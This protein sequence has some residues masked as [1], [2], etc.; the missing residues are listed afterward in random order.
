MPSWAQV[1]D[2]MN[3]S[4]VPN[5]PGSITNASE[6]SAMRA[7][8]SCMELTT[9]RWLKVSCAISWPASDSVMTPV[10]RPPAAS[11]ASATTPMR[12]TE[13]PP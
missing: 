13:A 9:C 11:A 7:L 2:S 3:S 5:P 8:R 12:P 4:Y 6:S 10:A 1:T